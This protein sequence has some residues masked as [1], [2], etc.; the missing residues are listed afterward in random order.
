MRKRT[1]PTIVEKALDTVNGFNAVYHRLKQQV[2][3][4]GQSKSTLENYIRRIAII[5]LHFGKLPEE[6][7]DD[8]I[9]EYLASLALSSKTPFYCTA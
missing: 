4:K 1:E 8:E 5:S 7:S 9:N 3:L 6:V 2:A